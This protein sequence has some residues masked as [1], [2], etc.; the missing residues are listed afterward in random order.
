[1][2]LVSQVTSLGADII[3]A[4][5]RTRLPIITTRFLKVTITRQSPSL[6]L[7]VLPHSQ[8]I[9][10]NLVCSIQRNKKAGWLMLDVVTSSL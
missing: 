10:D 7:C 1:M 3:G 2:S 8:H 4:M 9:P 6:S 5:A